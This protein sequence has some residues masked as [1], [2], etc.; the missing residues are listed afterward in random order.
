MPKAEK[1]QL[2]LAI[3]DANMQIS[4]LRDMQNELTINL[5]DHS[6]ALK[7]LEIKYKEKELE[8]GTLR[9]EYESVSETLSN[10][11]IKAEKGLA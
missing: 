2:N 5:T 1:E 4:N 6:D 3:K 11:L 10:L 8:L 9:E 7:K